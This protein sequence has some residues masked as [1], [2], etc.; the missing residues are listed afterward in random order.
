MGLT[1]ASTAGVRK[2]APKRLLQHALFRLGYKVQRLNPEERSAFVQFQRPDDT[3]IETVFGSDA[4]RLQE[5]RERYALVRSPAVAHSIWANRKSQSNL[6]DI[7]LAG[8]DLTR[9]RASSSYVWNYYGDGTADLARLQYYVFAQAVK[10]GDSAGLLDRLEEDGAFGCTTFDFESIGRVSR[11]LLDSVAEINFLQRHLDVLDRDDLRV[12]DIGAGYGRLAHRLLDANPRMA[13]YTCV[14]AVPESTFLSEFY[15]KF[16][17]LQDRV[18]VVALD[19]VDE[20]L[21]GEQFDVA[22]NIHGFSECTFA[23]I[24]WWLQRVRRSNVPHLMIVPNEEDRFLSTEVDGSRRDYR[25]LLTDLGYD[26]V[27]AEPVFDSTVRSLL[28]V[29]DMMFL[30]RLTTPD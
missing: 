19:T 6:T 18:D 20:R 17:G 21:K 4:D 15:L 23:A 3:A 8:V 7:G 1:E 10:A 28:G 13:G 25:P 30:F 27:A 14:D 2:A 22:I 12:L 16:R 26:V 5:L 9:F 29:A 24:E 11:D